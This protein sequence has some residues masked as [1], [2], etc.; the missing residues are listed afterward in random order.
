MVLIAS[1]IVKEC[2]GFS[3][4][5]RRRSREFGCRDSQTGGGV[6]VEM[7]NCRVLINVVSVRREGAVSVEPAFKRMKKISQ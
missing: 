7:M 1:Q 4:G 3:G 2:P 5:G 6:E